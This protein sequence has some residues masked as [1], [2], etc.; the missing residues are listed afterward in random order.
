MRSVLNTDKTPSTIEQSFKAA[1]KL[2]RE[3][4]T[5]I[6]IEFIPPMEFLTCEDFGELIK[7]CRIY[8]AN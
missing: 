8:S 4:L 5:D 2:K 7:A 1:S 3:L 6:D